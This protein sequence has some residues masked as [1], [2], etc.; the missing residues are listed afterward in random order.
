VPDDP[1]LNIYGHPL[2]PA[3][4]NEDPIAG[5]EVDG[6]GTN[7]LV[8]PEFFD[9]YTGFKPLLLQQ[10]DIDRFGELCPDYV[11]AHVDDTLAIPRE[12][13]EL[14]IRRRA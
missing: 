7:E 14:V 2:L 3:G 8:S 11:V 1:L 4:Y 5:D 9:S 12:V 6:A 10:E 13:N